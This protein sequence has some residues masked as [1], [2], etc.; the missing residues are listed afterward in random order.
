L[1]R[2]NSLREGLLSF[3]TPSEQLVNNEHKH[4]AQD[5]NRTITS[6]YIENSNLYAGRSTNTN[7][8]GDRQCSQMEDQ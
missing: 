3:K 8:G 7:R 4:E 6:S 5:L 2:T 1:R